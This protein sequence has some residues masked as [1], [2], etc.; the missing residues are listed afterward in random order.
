MATFQETWIDEYDDIPT[1]TTAAVMFREFV[2][3]MKTFLCGEDPVNTNGAWTVQGSSDG[4]LNVGASDYWVDSG[5]IVSANNGSSHSWIVLRSPTGYLPNSKYVEILIDCNTDAGGTDTEELQIWATTDVS[6]FAVGSGTLAYSPQHALGGGP[7]T[8]QR[9]ITGNGS[10]DPQI[11]ENDPSNDDHRLHMIRNE[12][13]DFIIMISKDGTG[14]AEW[15]WATL[16]TDPPS[17]SDDNYPVGMNARRLIATGPT[18]SQGFGSTSF[19]FEAWWID[20][21]DDAGD[22]FSSTCPSLTQ[23]VDGTVDKINGGRIP[24]IPI[25]IWSN[26]TTSNQVGYRGLIPDLRYAGDA[27]GLGPHVLLDANP[28]ADSFQY[29][30]MNG[31]YLPITATTTAPTL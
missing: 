12:R 14:F 31:L 20:G 7:T 25:L 9:E 1:Q 2:Y 19:G 21:D 26:S 22:L 16:T 13:G 11:L 6:A 17:T 5:D 3:R 15:T 4:D 30:K 24:K 10:T 28:G 18:F 23:G 27:G 29:V 8:V